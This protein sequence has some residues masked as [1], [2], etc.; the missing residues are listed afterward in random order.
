MSG[1]VSGSVVTYG[2]AHRRDGLRPF[3]MSKR[4][5][6]VLDGKDPT[7]RLRRSTTLLCE[8]VGEYVAATVWRRQNRNCLHDFSVKLKL[9]P[10]LTM[11]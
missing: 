10:R 4:E 5:L 7:L 1:K 11:R 6:S 8:V 2:P 3:C 9:E